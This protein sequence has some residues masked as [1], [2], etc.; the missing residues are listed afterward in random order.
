MHRKRKRNNERRKYINSKKCG[1][2]Y[3]PIYDANYILME[4]IEQATTCLR[5]LYP[6]ALGQYLVEWSILETRERFLP[7]TNQ[8]WA[9]NNRDA[10]R[11]HTKDQ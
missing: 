6:G 9:F 7:T 2:Y 1:L 10:E 4:Y 8:N 5:Q 3:L 11:L